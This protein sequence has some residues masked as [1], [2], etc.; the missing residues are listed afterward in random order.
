MRIYSEY[1]RLAGSLHGLQFFVVHG[2]SVLLNYAAVVPLAQSP[3]IAEIHCAPDTSIEQQ[4]EGD[5]SVHKLNLDAD[6]M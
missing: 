4:Q 2:N 1:G 5:L 6:I 3:G